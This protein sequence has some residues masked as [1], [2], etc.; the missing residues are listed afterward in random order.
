MADTEKT[1]MA[2]PEV[3]AEIIAA[4]GEDVDGDD[5]SGFAFGELLPR[6]EAGQPPL[7]PKDAGS[8]GGMVDPT[9]AG[10]TAWKKIG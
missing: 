7:R 4:L 9:E 2:P 5:V 1:F 6:V 3:A 8:A 10:W